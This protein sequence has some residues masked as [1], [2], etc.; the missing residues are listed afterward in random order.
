MAKLVAS[1]MEVG[2]LR[3]LKPCAPIAPHGGSL[4]KPFP[5]EP[6]LP[7]FGQKLEVI[8]KRQDDHK[9]ENP[10]PENNMPLVRGPIFLSAFAISVLV[11]TALSAAPLSKEQIH[12]EI[13]GKTLSGKRMGITV[14]IIYQLDGAVTI[15]SPV[16]SGSGTWSYSETGICMDMESG[17][18]LG[19]RCVTFEYLGGGDYRNSEGMT[20]TVQN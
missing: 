9:V 14:K 2:R 10:K 3:L 7:S 5:P 16:M 20:L 15:K 17:P 11:T 18:R 13:I 1:R 4:C 12:Q 8:E 6:H 19:K